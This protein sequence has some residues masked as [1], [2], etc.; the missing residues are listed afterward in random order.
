M[1]RVE[2]D[3]ELRE[4]LRKKAASIVVEASTCC[5]IDYEGPVAEV[6]DPRELREM[7]DN[8]RVVIAFFYTPTCPY[9]RM[10][11]PV[12]EEAARFY[13]GKALFAAVNLARF[14]FM[15]DALG[16]MGTPTI[17][18]FVRGREAGR[19]V[20]LMP[21]ERLEAFVEAVLDAGGCV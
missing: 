20:G 15:S 13:R 14:P 21:P 8:C 18:A 12:F 3:P 9:C 10:L 2:I 6:L 5:R 16:I 7:L 1:I 4:I 11:K 17:I 19:L